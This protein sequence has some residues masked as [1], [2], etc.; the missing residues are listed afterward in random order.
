MEVAIYTA[1]YNNCNLPNVREQEERVRRQIISMMKN[2]VS[3]PKDQHIFNVVSDKFNMYE[4]EVNGSTININR[5]W[6]I[7]IN[8]RIGLQSL[9][10]QMGNNNIDVL[11]VYN[12]EVFSSNPDTLS[13]ITDQIL[14]RYNISTIFVN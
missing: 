2:S 14:R 8:N 12:P 3:S 6:N 11:A 1:T 13:F 4:D 7:I 5:D 10:N 9:L